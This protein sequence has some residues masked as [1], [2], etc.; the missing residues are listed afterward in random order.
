MPVELVDTGAVDLAA[1]PTE[2]TQVRLCILFGYL[3]QGHADIFCCFATNIRLGNLENVEV[4]RMVMLK[5]RS[6]TG[7]VPV[8]MPQEGALHTKQAMR[9]PDIICQAHDL[10][11]QDD[12]VRLSFSVRRELHRKLKLKAVASSRTISSMVEEW[13][14]EHLRI[15]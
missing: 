14:D 7:G 1:P 11:E 6:A 8:A 4:C 10:H 9:G 3:G 15:N 13:I 5:K 2:R 12:T